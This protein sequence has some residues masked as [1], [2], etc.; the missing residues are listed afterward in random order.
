[1]SDIFISYS[2]KDK[3]FVIGLHKTLEA[4]K[5]RTGWTWRTS[6]PPPNGV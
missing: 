6:L 2:R 5:G 4:K 3:D 1:M